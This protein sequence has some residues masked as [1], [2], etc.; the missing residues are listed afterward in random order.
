MYTYK[1]SIHVCQPQTERYLGTH[2]CQI[3]A[4]IT[5]TESSLIAYV[6]TDAELVC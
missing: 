2:K 4:E 6:D 3:N 1:N 5:T